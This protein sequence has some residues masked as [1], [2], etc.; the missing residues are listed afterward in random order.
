MNYDEERNS[1]AKW[2]IILAILLVAAFT[3]FDLLKILPIISDGLKLSGIV[4]CFLFSITLLF[5]MEADLDRVLLMV[6]LFFAIIADTLLLFTELYFFGVLAFCVVQ[7]L[8]SVR[9]F[10]IKRSVVRMDGRIFSSYRSYKVHN[11]VLLVNLVQLLFAAVPVAV[12]FFVKVPDVELISACVFYIVG[13]IGN[14]LTLASLSRDVRLLDDMR[15]LRVYFVGMLLYF[16]CDV[17]LGVFR[18]PEYIPVLPQLTEYIS[19]A[20]LVIWPLYLA[21]MVCISLSGVRRQRFYS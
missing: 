14:L 16:V 10:S 12:S 5:S 13:F 18:M 21:G 20:M 6:S 1:L 19:Y 9:I 7:E 11:R 17:L 4:L 3:A 2:F 15:P 8:H